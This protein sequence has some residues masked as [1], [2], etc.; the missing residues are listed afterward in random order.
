MRAGSLRHLATV[1]R[2]SDTPNAFGERPWEELGTYWCSVKQR[3]TIERAE[4]GETFSK[5]RYDLLFRYAAALV[6]LPAS[7]EIELDGERLQV[8]TAADP[9]GKHKVAFITAEARE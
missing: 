4:N 7:A 3:Y 6:T 5:V 2:R 9:D 8:L 1:H